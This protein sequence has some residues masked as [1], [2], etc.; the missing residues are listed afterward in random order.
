MI[1]SYKTVYEG[2]SGEIITKKSRFIATVNPAGTEKE[3]NLFIENMKKKYRDASHN[4]SAYIIGSHNSIMHCSDDGEPAKTAGWP[5]LDI[6]ISNTLTNIV[7][8]VTRYF[9]GT[10]LGTGGLARAYRAA[11]QKGI[12]NSKI[13]TKEPGV[14]LLIT[15]NYNYIGK[16]QYI[17]GQEQL[18]ILSSEY[19]DIV[20]LSILV[21]I[22]KKQVITKKITELTNGSAILEDHGHIYFGFINHEL[23]LF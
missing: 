13:I 18:P 10:L 14:R 11:A 23:H 19:L 22:N 9:G 6:L 15:T 3:A 4:C 21:P 5:I 17:I 2:K 7:I 20:K 12:N 8:V 1:E 16:I